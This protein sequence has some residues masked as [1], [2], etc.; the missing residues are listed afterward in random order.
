M[1]LCC[2]VFRAHCATF[3]TVGTHNLYNDVHTYYGSFPLQLSKSLNLVE[4]S[5]TVRYLEKNYFCGQTVNTT[6]Q[7]MNYFLSYLKIKVATID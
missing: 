7:L 3:Q 5:H 2:V 6:E 4:L 1:T